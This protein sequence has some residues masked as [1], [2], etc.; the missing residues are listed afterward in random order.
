VSGI[1]AIRSASV[2]TAITVVTVP[3]AAGSLGLIFAGVALT[4]PGRDATRRSH[5]RS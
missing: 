4:L 1:S 2:R 5:R 3:V